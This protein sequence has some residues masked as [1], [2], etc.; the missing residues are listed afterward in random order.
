MSVLS[1]MSF[2]TMNDLKLALSKFQALQRDL[3]NDVQ[4]SRPYRK[5]HRYRRD[6]ESNRSQVQVPRLASH[7]QPLQG[8]PNLQEAAAKRK[9]ISANVANN[10]GLPVQFTP[11]EVHFVVDTGASVTIT[12]SKSD[13]ISPISPVQPTKLQG[14]ASG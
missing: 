5:Q 8:T 3:L 1:L 10:Q 4:H 2:A 7:Y 9:A 6:L 13:F 14:I 12:N 11:D